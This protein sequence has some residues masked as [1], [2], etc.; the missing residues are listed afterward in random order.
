MARSINI[1]ALA[2]HNFQTGED[3]I[4]IKY[5]KTKADQSGELVR[6]KH[7]Y[8]NPFSL[9][10]C[11]VLALGIWFTLESTPLATS[12]MLFGSEQTEENAPA[13]KYTTQLAELLQNNI[14][15]VR[16]FVRKN[17]ASVHGIRKGSASYATSGTTVC[18]ATSL[19]EMSAIQKS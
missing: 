12:P 13:K 10:C 15:M 11:P 18:Y 5:D 19:K 1:A 2:Y 17:H 3:F 14:D 4:K 16:R 9:I 6:V 8:V 7:V